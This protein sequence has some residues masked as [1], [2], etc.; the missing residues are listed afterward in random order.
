MNG[1]REE[2][3]GWERLRWAAKLADWA[4]GAPAGA[5]AAAAALEG[6]LR[7]RFDCA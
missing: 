1:C 5:A 3:K 2:M 6:L 4:G 7:G